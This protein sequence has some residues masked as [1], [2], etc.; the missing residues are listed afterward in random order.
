MLRVVRVTERPFSDLLRHPKDVAG[1]VDE[2]DVV[3]RRRDEPDLW[4]SRADREADRSET[5]AAVGRALRNLAVHSPTALADSLVDAFPWT[6]F[7]P[8]AERRLFV[9]EFSRVLTAG[10]E[11]DNLTPL[12][13]MLREWRATAE[14]HADPLLARR[15]R[16]KLQAA[17]NAVAVPGA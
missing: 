14:V 9:D 16:R 2:G 1:D 12:T 17:G 15:L 3:L 7:L 5:F 13:Q 4:L 8:A 10:A 6:L 11:L